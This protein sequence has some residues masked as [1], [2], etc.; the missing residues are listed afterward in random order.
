MDIAKAISKSWKLC[1]Q[2]LHVLLPGII[3]MAVMLPLLVVFVYGSGLR[4]LWAEQEQLRH[5]FDQQ[6]LD[7]LGKMQMGNEN[8][9]TALLLTVG[10]RSSAY[11]TAFNTYLEEQG[12]DWDKWADLFSVRNVAMLIAFVCVGLL[13]SWYASCMTFVLIMLRMRNKHSWSGAWR[14]TNKYLLRLLGARVLVLIAIL[15]PLVVLVPL[16]LLIKS[17]P[18][19]AFVFILALLLFLVYIVYMNLRLLFVVPALF[20]EQKGVIESLRSSLRMTRAKLKY[21]FLIFLLILAFSLIVRGSVMN[22]Q[23]DVF[24]RFLGSGGVL[25]V[26][27]FSLLA[28]LTLLQVALQTFQNVFLFYAFEEGKNKKK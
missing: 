3:S 14:L 22:P 26:L 17:I 20:L 12:Y 23:G 1:T 24:V 2:N 13:V 6:Q 19:I 16:V 11:N 9:L 4:P 5:A 15:G 28:F 7:T 25:S 8:F 18:L 21:A 10:R 27:L